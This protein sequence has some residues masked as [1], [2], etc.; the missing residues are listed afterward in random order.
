[1]SSFEQDGSKQ[2]LWTLLSLFSRLDRH[3]RDYYRKKLQLPLLLKL[4]GSKT[5]PHPRE[6]AMQ[7]EIHFGNFFS[8]HFTSSEGS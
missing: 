7:R 5:N 2:L 6:L 3:A 4:P 8:C 1:M